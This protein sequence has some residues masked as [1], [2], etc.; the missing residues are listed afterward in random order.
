MQLSFWGSFL[1][2][3]AGSL[4]LFELYKLLDA[5]RKRAIE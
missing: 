4:C 5:Y 2:D 1:I 3:I